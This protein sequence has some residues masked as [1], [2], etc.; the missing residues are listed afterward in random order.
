M[1]LSQQ[2][3]GNEYSEE[4]SIAKMTD[5]ELLI[6][7]IIDKLNKRYKKEIQPHYFSL[8]EFEMKKNKLILEI[9]KDGI[10]LM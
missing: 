5:D 8:S 1:S 3:V 6:T 10:V 4:T 9:E 7:E 2:P